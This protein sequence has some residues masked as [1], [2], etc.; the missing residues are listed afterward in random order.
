MPLDQQ[1]LWRQQA[2]GTAFQ[3]TL[4]GLWEQSDSL[5]PSVLGFLSS[6]FPSPSSL[7]LSSPLFRSILFSSPSLLLSLPPLPRWP[8]SL[9]STRATLGTSSRDSSPSPPPCPRVS[10]TPYII[11]TITTVACQ[12]LGPV[13]SRSPHP[14]LFTP[15]PQRRLS[16]CQKSPESECH[17]QV[18]PHRRLP[19]KPHQ[20]SLARP[21]S[22]SR[23]ARIPT[24][25]LAVPRIIVIR[26]GTFFSSRKGR[27]RV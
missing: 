12:L 2:L 5:N 6:F 26:D 3:V 1:Q 22:R 24:Q 15:K 13:P 19:S 7:S 4:R 25:L 23:R 9:K 10:Y 20:R 11:I 27:A 17:Q 16:T 21:S 18:P 8:F 14:P